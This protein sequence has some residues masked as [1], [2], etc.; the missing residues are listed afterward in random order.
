MHFTLNTEMCVLFLKY[1]PTGSSPYV[2]IVAS[3]RD[4]YYDR[5]TQR[6]MY[7]KEHPTILA[8]TAC[9][10]LALYYMEMHVSYM[11]IFGMTCIVPSQTN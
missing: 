10:L 3:N 4:E 1:D 11:C 2:L 6:A 9:N 7:W 5:A 8:G